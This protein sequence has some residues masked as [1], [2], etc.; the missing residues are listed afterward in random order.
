VRN[1]GPIPK[2]SYSIG[3]AFRH[4]KKGPVVMRL[5]PSGTQNMFGRSGFLIHGNNVRNDASQGCIILSRPIRSQISAS[6][7]RDLTVVF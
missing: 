2:G 4:P 1:T 5:T 6:S 3:N 7:D